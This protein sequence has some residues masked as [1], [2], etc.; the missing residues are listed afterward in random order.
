MK[1]KSFAQAPN[2]AGGTPDS[3]QSYAGLSP[4]TKQLV[5]E[6]LSRADVARELKTCT[7]TIARLTRKGVLPC[8]KFNS[9]LIRYRREDVDK[10]ISSARV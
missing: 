6:L 5:I 4:Q 8:L 1:P 3:N 9:R 2:G 7:H 10:F